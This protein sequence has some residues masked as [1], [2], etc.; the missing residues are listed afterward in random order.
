MCL[1]YIIFYFIG[2]LTTERVSP[3]SASKSS[4]SEDSLCLGLFEVC[5]ALEF[6]HQAGV[7][8]GNVSQ[9]SIYVSQD[10]RWRLGGLESVSSATDGALAKDIQ[11]LGLVISEILAN[12]KEEQ[13]V[14][15][16][17]FAKNSLLLP[18]IKRIPSSKDILQDDYFQQSFVKI[19]QF[20]VK[21]PV[22]SEEEREKFFQTCTDQLKCLSPETVAT[23]LVPHLLSRYIMI[24]SRSQDDI[25]P[26]ILI[27]QSSTPPLGVDP[28]LPLHLYHSHVVPQ[29]KLLF[30][31][32]DTNIRLTLLKIWPN[33]VTH[34]PE[35]I[36]NYGINC[37]LN[38][39]LLPPVDI[40]L[41]KQNVNC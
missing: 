31:V 28:I 38:I 8:H 6:L 41:N 26:N 12:C 4:L 25:V 11:A 18:D 37:M 34:I 14:K 16:R 19:F 21:F 29:L 32:P 17:D 27:P 20:L 7:C 9:L 3:L 35:V 36:C 33:F 2:C 10:G 15:F 30:S 39:E 22:Q 40:K 24:D 13:S 1:H 23:H 5:Q